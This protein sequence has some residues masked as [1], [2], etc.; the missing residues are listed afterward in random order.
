M[1]DEP[2]TRVKNAIRRSILRGEIAKLRVRCTAD[3]LRAIE[4]S[5]ISE[6]VDWE[7]LPACNGAQ[8]W[9]LQIECR[10]ESQND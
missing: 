3:E 2:A 9:Y 8:D 5:T 1:T 10:E 6:C 4:R 7:R